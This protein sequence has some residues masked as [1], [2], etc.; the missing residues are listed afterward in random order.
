MTIGLQGTW[1]VSVASKSAAWQQ[2]FTIAGSSNGA[3][4]TYDGLTTTPPVLVTGEQWGVTIENNP[5]GPIEWQPSRMRLANFRVD[6]SF[7]KVDL[8]SDDG[9]GGDADFNDL[10]LTAAMPLAA[11]DW[12]VYGTAKSYSGWCLINPCFPFPW[13]V[14]DT[15]L[16]LERLLA[17]PDVRPILERAYGP[18]VADLAS[19]E[20][21]TPLVLPLGGRSTEGL[22]VRGATSVELAKKSRGKDV[23]LKVAEE[24]IVGRALSPQYTT[25]FTRDELDV[26]GKLRFPFTCTVE[27]IAEALLRFVEY[28]R[29]DA[30]LAGD[31][32]TGFGDRETLGVTATDEFGNYVF[33]FSRSLDQIVDEALNDVPAGGD[34]TIGA[35]PDLIIQFVDEPDGIARHETAPYYDIPNVRRIDLCIPAAAL[36]PKPCRGDRVL[37]YLGDI[38]IVTNPFSKLWSDG[39]VSNLPGTEAGPIVRH[40]AWRGTVDI[41]GCFEG[42]TTPVTHYTMEVR[43]DSEPWTFLNVQA[44][45][46][47]QQGTSVWTTESYGPTNESLHVN[48]ALLPA[49]TVPAYRNIELE[50][51]WSLYVEHLKARV[52]VESYLPATL[53]R[54]VGTVSFRIRGY[55]AG[56]NPVAGTSDTVALLVDDAPATGEIGSITVAGG[57]DPGDCALLELPAAGTPL[58]IRLRATDPD[59]FLA[60]WSLSAVRGSNHPVGLIDGATSAPVGGDYAD[61]TPFRFHGTSE[62]TGADLDGFV[63]LSVTPT[64]G[65]WLQ[66]EDFCAFSFELAVTDRTTN[67]KTAPGSRKVWDE[68]IGMRPAPE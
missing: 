12:V 9:G 44:S 57:A 6:G 66:G 63:T 22:A 46:L 26:I 64:G 42:T 39:T 23:E 43:Y 67:G 17:Y 45:G 18:R 52:T 41:F 15:P 5:T 38:P 37:Q 7:F 1:T 58:D 30:E 59:G 14:I 32:Y 47:R 2:R 8:Q 34:A 35:R 33:A 27:P 4:G 53:P 40:A 48:G 3:D 51:G 25:P 56:G 21:F 49:V 29:T 55:D 19:R 20:R 13:V 31:P 60:A 65:D 24:A 16:Q 10:I 62:L 61:V 28:D 36:L 50:T 68:V 54:P 11:S